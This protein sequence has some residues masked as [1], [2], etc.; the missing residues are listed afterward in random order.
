MENVILN[1][2]KER[3]I[4][5]MSTPANLDDEETTTLVYK[6]DWVRILL[7]QD[8]EKN[9][10]EVEVS[11][12]DDGGCETADSTAIFDK[13]TEHVNY[14]QNLK[15]Y[16]FKLCIYGSGCILTASKNLLKPPEDNL[17]SALHPP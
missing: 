1:N 8:N 5:A 2:L 7:E 9:S 11:L 13:F 17:F 16:G 6:N 10:I 15:Q 14:L 3:F 4:E 12:P